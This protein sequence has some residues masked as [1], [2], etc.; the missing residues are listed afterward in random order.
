MEKLK[1]IVTLFV[2]FV[3][4]LAVAHTF[5]GH[6]HVNDIVSN[7][8]SS[9][10]HCTKESK[11]VLSNGKEVNE[12]FEH[13]GHCDPN[14]YDFLSCILGQIP[15]SETVEYQQENEFNVLLLKTPKALRA[16]VVF[17][18]VNYS[19]ENLKEEVPPSASFAKNLTSL[20][21]L[22]SASKRGPPTLF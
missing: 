8:T 19:I 13:K 7:F 12:H 15:H 17:I 9:K 4:T 1:K 3:Y 11:I 14:I 20:I 22:S 2:L 6:N 18:F 16:L 10:S 21:P 5:V